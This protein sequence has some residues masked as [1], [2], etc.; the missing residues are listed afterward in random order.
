[1]WNRVVLLVLGVAFGWSLA[2]YASA[3]PERQRTHLGRMLVAAVA[4]LF[5]AVW[6]GM[7][8]PVA[9]GMAA[10]VL[11]VSALAAYA[12]NA[13]Q[14]NRAGQRDTLPRPQ[15][16]LGGQ[17]GL[18]L[19]LVQPG[20]PRTYD[21][22]DHWA[23]RLR[24][25]ALDGQPIPHWFVRP[26]AYGR[27]RQAY[28]RMGGENPR[29]AALDALV[30][31]LTARLPQI[32]LFGYAFPDTA[33]ILSAELARLAQ[34][35]TRRI[36]LVPI[37]FRRDPADVLRD[38]ITRAHVRELGAQVEIAPSLEAGLWPWEDSDTVLD[39]LLGGEPLPAPAVPSEL[40]IAALA[41]A[42]ER[43]AL[44]GPRPEW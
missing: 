7:S 4:G 29:H 1:M 13:R 22:P 10:F 20:E 14:V 23:R 6:L 44:P 33:P 15:A 36:V 3:A 41:E 26:W 21:G 18:A 34:Q 17:D 5:F 37:G 32:E 27:I 11:V 25:R 19:L 38:E 2:H 28:Q 31:R 40:Q 16:L 39:R 24:Q 9:G 42:L 12:A 43:R 30:P 35:G 8:S